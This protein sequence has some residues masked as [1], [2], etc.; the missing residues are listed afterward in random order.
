MNWVDFLTDNNIEYVTRGPNTKRGE[1]SIKCPF[2]GEG[3]DDPSQHMG[4]STIRDAWGCL[5]NSRHRGL[6]P[7]RL[8]AAI[9]GCSS[10][11][12]RL[13]VSQYSESDPESL[14]V[15]PSPAESAGPE[16]DPPILRSIKPNDRFWQYLEIRGYGDAVFSVVEQY[17]LACCTTGRFKDRIII[18]FY[19]GGKLIAWS[20]RAIVDPKL[21]PRYLSSNLIKTI[22]FNEEQLS[23]GGRVLYVVEG[24][25]DAMKLDYYGQEYG[26]RATCGSGINMTA[27]QTVILNTV[28][29][30]FDKVVV[31]FDAGTLEQAFVAMDWL[32]H[33]NVKLGQLPEGVKDPGELDH[34]A[35][36]SMIHEE[37]P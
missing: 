14:G 19:R 11:Q 10:Y 18:P 7:D 16:I 37:L 9:I 8:V 30:R 15:A 35:I 20:G 29:Q 21:A 32:H 28:A 1:I 6:Q 27:A 4:I 3:D 23:S 17:R 24:P 36:T 2:C 34:S 22:I 31:L 26:V 13:I 12:A 25:F 5:R 33:P